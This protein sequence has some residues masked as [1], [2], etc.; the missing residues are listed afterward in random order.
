MARKTPNV[1]ESVKTKPASPSKCFLE[2]DPSGIINYYVRWDIE[3]QMTLLLQQMDNPD[4]S[5]RRF[6]DP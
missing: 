2:P 6:Q 1:D 5:Q 3:N 4:T